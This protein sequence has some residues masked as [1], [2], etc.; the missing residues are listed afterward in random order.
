MVNRLTPTEVV[1]ALIGS[2]E[3]VGEVAERDRTSL[4]KWRHSSRHRAPGDLPGAEVMR[5]LLDY[6]RAH[7]IP[8]TA[9]HLIYGA[10]EAEIAALAA[11]AQ[12]AAA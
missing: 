2:A 6:A 12:D 11:P 10:A 3:R 4:Y 8:L 9:E 7:D 5:R 1:I